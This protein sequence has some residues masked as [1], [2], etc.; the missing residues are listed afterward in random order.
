[1]NKH[2]RINCVIALVAFLLSSFYVAAQDQPVI[3]FITIQASRQ[4]QIKGNSPG[5]GKQGQIECI[6]FTFSAQSPRDPAT[7]L[8][9]G[10]AD[11]SPVTI[12]KH[13]DGATPQ[14]LQALYTNEPLPSVLIEFSRKGM[15]GRLAVYQTIRLTNATIGKIAQ[16]GGVECSDK[17]IPNTSPIEQVSFT[18]QKMEV[19]N[20]ESRT[21][22]TDSW[23][24]R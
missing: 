19:D 21:T 24:A 23:N 16:F 17:L 12:V 4:G 5:M 10:R 3:A 6:G 13:L 11:R 8:P 1:M 20:L 15:D 18:Y 9:T 2:A 14:L 7:G 22:M